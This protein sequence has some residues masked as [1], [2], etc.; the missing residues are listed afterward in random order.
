M[1]FVFDITVNGEHGFCEIVDEKRAE[2]FCKK[3]LFKSENK[4]ECEEFANK[5]FLKIKNY[6]NIKPVN[7]DLWSD[8]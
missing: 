6:E 7:N 3:E 1:W 4:S 2:N 5:N 8:F